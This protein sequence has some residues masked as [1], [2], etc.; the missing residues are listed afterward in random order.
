MGVLHDFERRLEGAVDG[1]FARIFSSGLQPVELAKGLQRYARD[2]QH[3]SHDGVVVPNVYR[4]RIAP[5]DH[6][7]LSRLGVDLRGELSGVVTGTAR[8][9][10]WILRGPAAVV[11]EVGS[12]AVGRYELS[13]RIEPVTGDTSGPI[14]TEPAEPASPVQPAA[15]ADDGMAHTQV[16][17]ALGGAVSTPTVRVLAGGLT[18][19]VQLAG[20]TV[21]G[22]APGCGILLSDTTVSREHAA[23]IRRDDAWWV[24]D[25]GSM[26]GTKVNGRVAAE[27]PLR[28][29]D[30]VLLGDASLEFVER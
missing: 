12:V 23:F 26:N 16:L 15:D 3:V 25:L 24:M 30:A 19:D 18:A 7:R 13:G 10:G 29:G 9:K 4:F 11:I 17:G 14:L 5:K 2:T 21:A 28:H 27:H 6:D 1:V 22:R 8:E 20:R